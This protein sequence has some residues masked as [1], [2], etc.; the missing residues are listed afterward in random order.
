MLL[1]RFIFIHNYN[2]FRIAR[3]SFLYMDSNYLRKLFNL[4]LIRM[5]YCC[6]SKKINKKDKFFS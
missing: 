6:L 2:E 1:V 3:S 4:Q 5:F